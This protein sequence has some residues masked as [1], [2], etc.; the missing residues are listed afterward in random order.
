[1]NGTCEVE[2]GIFAAVVVATTARG[3]MLDTTVVGADGEAVV[4][5]VRAAMAGG[6]VVTVVGAAIVRGVMVTVIGA[7]VAG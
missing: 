1:M 7:A 4:T 6:A 3:D 2:E 5:V